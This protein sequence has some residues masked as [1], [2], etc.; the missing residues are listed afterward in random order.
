MCTS[1][2]RSWQ[3]LRSLEP[4]FISQIR[5]VIVYDI[6][7]HSALIVTKD[8]MV[9]ALGINHFGCLGTGDC[10]ST[11]HPKKIEVLCTKD[12]KTFACGGGPHVL[13]LTVGGEIYS[14]GY[15][16]YG[17]VG[18]SW[19]ESITTPALVNIPIQEGDQGPKRIVDIACGCNHSIALTES[20]EVYAWGVHED[21]EEE[22]EEVQEE[23]QEQEK[24]KTDK[25]TTPMQ[26]DILVKKKVVH[27]SCGAAFTVV[28]IDNG[29][30]YGWGNNRY[31][32][33]GVGDM[34]DR[35]TPCQVDS[36]IGT[37]IVQVVCGDRHTLALTDKGDLYAWGNNYY[38]QL[39]I[40]NK[41]HSVKP[42]LVEHQMGR[43]FD[44][45]A[46]YDDNISV[47]VGTG[48]R[49]YVWGFCCG[50]NIMTPIATPFSDIHIAFAS[51]SLMTY[52]HKPLFLDINGEPDIEC[53]VL[54]VRTAFS[55][56]STSDLR[57]QVG[58]YFMHVHKI[59]L[60]V[61]SSYFQTLFQHDW[62]EN[63]QS[64]I[65]L[66]QFSY[67]V[68]KAFLKYLYTDIVDLPWKQVVGLLDLADAYCESDLRK[69]CFQMLKKEITVP[70]VVYLYTIAVK[71]NEEELED[72]CVRFAVH[73]M[74]AV[75]MTEDFAKL[76]QELMMTSFIIKARRAGCFKY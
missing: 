19:N 7:G 55:D 46:M 73:H 69:K 42:V 66:D 47:A 65:K 62:A 6:Y 34:E 17:Q 15:N 59:I 44:I 13:A 51:Y 60:K 39:G 68:Y 31:G 57:I 58:N 32:Q 21:E 56:S 27:I 22:E 54:K 26:F 23:E 28:I 18:N 8:K 53:D 72:C 35:T 10:I 71:Y 41:T 67:I 9:Y 29:E 49:V 3:V 36:L 43:V 14:W 30:V 12:I 76:E 4:E 2:L 50:Q 40:G 61:R 52:M 75:T 37:V 38:G 33:L 24:E 70:N 48:Q 1:V 20:G 5:M 64:V 16:L 63:N 11:L 74:N 45:A 25:Q